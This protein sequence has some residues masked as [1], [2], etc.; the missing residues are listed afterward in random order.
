[1]RQTS[2]S[3]TFAKS[4][5]IQKQYKKNVWEK[6]NDAYKLSIRVQTMINHIFVFIVFFYDNI[7]IKENVFF[8]SA[9]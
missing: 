8:Q 3:K 9:S 4:L 2:L 6:S 1:M 7:N 5:N